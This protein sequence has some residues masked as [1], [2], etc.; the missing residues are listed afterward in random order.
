MSISHSLINSRL[1]MRTIEKKMETCQKWAEGRGVASIPHMNTRNG[2]PMVMSVAWYKWSA[3]I[4]ANTNVCQCAAIRCITSIMNRSSG[5]ILRLNS[6]ACCVSSACSGDSDGPSEVDPGPG[7][8]PS[9]NPSTESGTRASADCSRRCRNPIGGRARRGE[10]VPAVV[11]SSSRE[12]VPA[13]AFRLCF[14]PPVA[15]SA[16]EPCRL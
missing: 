9:L 12:L 8:D 2:K 10:S 7:P 5:G 1:Y 13:L 16:P 4:S 3:T 6:V 14:E 15:S 11:N